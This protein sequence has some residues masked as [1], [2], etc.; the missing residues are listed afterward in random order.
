MRMRKKP[1]LLSMT[2]VALALLA[3]PSLA[4][5]P[6]S[7]A[8]AAETENDALTDKVRELFDEGVKAANA[9]KWSDA[10]VSF[11]AAW[12]L[13]EHYQIASNLGV[14]ELKLGKYREAAEHL[15]WYLREAPASKVEQRRRAEQSLKEALAK[16]AQVTVE[17]EPAGADV[18]VDGAA[19]GKAPL[20][21]PVFL[22]PGEHEV[23]ARLDG[24]VPE[25]RGVTAKA[26]ATATVSLRLVAQAAA[27]AEQAGNGQIA[28]RMPA[29]PG[30]TSGPSKPLLYTGI[31]LTGVAAGLGAVFGIVSLNKESQAEDLHVV[32]EN[33]DGPS[34][35]ANGQNAAQCGE[36]WSARKDAWTY[37]K[38][39][40]GCFGGAAAIGAATLIYYWTAPRQASGVTR[41]QVIPHLGPTG[42]GI[43]ITGA[44]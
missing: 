41:A 32:L 5:Q 29:N 20:R 6:T 3:S 9:S 11:L 36:L 13:K 43:V 10:H 27:P 4:Q 42:S 37:T 26:G 1:S 14:A 18:T 33:K 39:A 7:T 23:G 12:R 25:K 35:C 44:W 22:N 31:A 16:V 24:H 34:A 28:P 30:D 19:V 21:M 38:A 8:P 15:T 2:G 40:W 17:V